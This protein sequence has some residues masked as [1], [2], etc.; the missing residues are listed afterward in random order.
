MESPAPV[1]DPNRLV[2]PGWH[3]DPWGQAPLRFWDGSTWT[4]YTHAGTV[5]APPALDDTAIRMLLPVG[6]SGWAIAAGYLGLVSVLL[7]FAPFALVTGILGLQA[8]R[9]D[10][11]LWGRGRAWFGVVMVGIFTVLLVVVMVASAARS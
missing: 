11:N 2:P 5:P 9:R 10:P 8:I 4:G 1:A 3:P 6:R 7:L